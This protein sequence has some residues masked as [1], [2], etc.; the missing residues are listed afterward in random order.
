M[1]WVDIK[2]ADPYAKQI[3]G[4]FN[5]RD[6]FVFEIFHGTREP[7]KYGYTHVLKLELPEKK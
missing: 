1:K 6:E 5:D 7:L 3:F 4:Y 2:E